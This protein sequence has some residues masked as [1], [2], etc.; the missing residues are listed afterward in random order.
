MRTLRRGSMREAAGV[1]N[2][3]IRAKMPPSTPI[4]TGLITTYY[5]QRT[6]TVVSYGY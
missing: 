4:I 1:D 6:T 5:V 2:L 3:K